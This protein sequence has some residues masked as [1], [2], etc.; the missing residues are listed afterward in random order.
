[1]SDVILKDSRLLKTNPYNMS[2]DLISYKNRY[3]IGFDLY[4]NF[5]SYL[6]GQNS[7]SVMRIDN[8]IDAQRYFD[9]YLNNLNNNLY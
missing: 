5:E 4:K 7:F 2:Y 9:E 1:M 3:Y 6:I 8:S